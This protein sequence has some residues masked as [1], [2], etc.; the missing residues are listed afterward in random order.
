MIHVCIGL[1]EIHESFILIYTLPFRVLDEKNNNMYTNDKPPLSS[2]R[3]RLDH[4]QT[5]TAVCT[6]F[7]EETAVD[8]ALVQVGALVAVVDDI[9]GSS[10]LL[11]YA[12]LE[13][14]TTNKVDGF[15]TRH[16]L[17]CAGAGRVVNCDL[18]GTLSALSE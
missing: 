2:L 17:E 11:Q 14:P 4:L 18:A 7:D 15:G 10:G 1:C 13:L 3:P 5:H 12:E 16:S 8:L 9:S 6:V